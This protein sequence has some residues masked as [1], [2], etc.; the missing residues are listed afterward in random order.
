MT[1]A[2]R[3]KL[4]VFRKKDREQIPDDRELI[5]I[6]LTEN[7]EAFEW[8]VAKYR[9]PVFWTAYRLLL[10]SEDARDV[11]Q[12]TFLK[13]WSSLSTYDAEKSF[14]G[15]ITKIAANCAIDMLRTRKSSEP[16]PEIPVS[17]HQLLESSQDIQ[18]IFLR[19]GPQ[20]PERQRIVLVLREIEGMEIPEIARTLDC[21]ESTVRNLLSQAKESFRKK[22]KELFP[23]Y[24]M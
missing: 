2:S 13:V 6:C 15:W 5:R 14:G 9:D 12:Q 17:P 21:T 19:I 24:G 4:F 20:L 7:S 10:D 18:K 22:V 3:Q 23:E 1:G 8:I 11:V 16:L